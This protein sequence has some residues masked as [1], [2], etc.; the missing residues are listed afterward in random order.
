MTD[1]S[2]YN[3]KFFRATSPVEN[4]LLLEMNRYVAGHPPA[5]SPSLHDSH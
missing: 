1:V 5:P 2:Q 4:V 3:G